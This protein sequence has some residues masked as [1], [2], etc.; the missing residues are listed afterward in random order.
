MTLPTWLRFDL[1]EVYRKLDEANELQGMYSTNC[2]A[3]EQNSL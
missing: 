3:L 2:T 1:I